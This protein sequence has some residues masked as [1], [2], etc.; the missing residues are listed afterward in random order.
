MTLSLT[1]YAGRWVAL[2]R[3]EV[4]AVG[5]SADEARASAQLS[6]PKA[7]PQVIFVPEPFDY[8]LPELIA[9]VR[10]AVPNPEHVWLVGGTVRDVMLNRRAHDVDFAVDGNGVAVARVVADT[11]RGAFY[12][13]DAER[14]TGRV[15][16][17]DPE[18]FIQTLDFATLRGPDIYADLA[19]R[20]F[21]LNALAVPLGSTDTLIDPLHGQQDLRAKVI[22]ACS[23]TAIADDSL[24]S[25]RAVRHAAELN[26]RIDK[27][28][29]AAIKAE[30]AALGR[31]SPERVRDEFIRCLGGP[32]P[33]A[34]VRALDLLGLLTHI[35]PELET[36][37][38]VT[39]SPPHTLDVW[40]HT[41][42]VVTRLEEVL[43]IL[44]LRHDVDAASD[45]ILGLV[46]LRLGRY[47]QQFNE[48]LSTALSS[49]RPTHWVLMLAALLHDAA[50]PQTL[51]VEADGRIRFLNHENLSADLTE[52]V[53]TRL[54]FSSDEITHAQTIV[55]NHMRPRQLSREGEPSA[56][57]VYRYW[58]DTSA[59]GVDIVLLS[60]ADYLG[61]F[62][63]S[64]PP[65]D[66]WA[67]HLAGCF[68]LLEAYFEKR[69]V[70]VA[71]P[72]LLNGN[73]L[74]N[75]LGLKPGPELGRLLEAVR[76]A[77]AAGEVTDRAEA[78]RLVRQLLGV[79]GT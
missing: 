43:R 11:L 67:Q 26:F 73:D 34:S 50:K 41:L 20:D 62:G 39:Q 49:E 10:Q 12:P 56:R 23:P 33:A 61:K 17:R 25:L 74:M 60:L 1:E 15:I 40:E 19:A 3:D 35:V 57:A 14:G 30:A 21:T 2:V 51:S 76:E 24:R 37:K 53:M 64:P 8:E 9:A 44:G 77:Q 6:Q 27:D 36:L 16:V 55:A 13:L 69:A 29:R 75:E 68:R 72:A 52:T 7:Q 42:A 70:N 54:R 32:Q 46:S 71:P 65:Q 78:L 48:H 5:A 38:G 58:R 31:V 79:N 47:R 66:E 18:G 22:R 59:A 63:G 4:I 28:T 45:L